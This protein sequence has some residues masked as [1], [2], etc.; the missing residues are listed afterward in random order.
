M[1]FCVCAADVSE[2]GHHLDLFFQNEADPPA[3]TEARRVEMAY[4]T[5]WIAEARGE[6]AL[7]LR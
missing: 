6:R 1:P 4:I 7:R 5:K 2:S 3:V